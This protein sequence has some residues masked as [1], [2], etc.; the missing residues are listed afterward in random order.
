MF[1]KSVQSPVGPWALGMIAHGEPARR[2]K[3]GE[4]WGE[5]GEGRGQA[6][7]FCLASKIVFF[8]LLYGKNP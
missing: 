6:N 5:G 4:E 2:R 8:L 3:E 7:S 1:C